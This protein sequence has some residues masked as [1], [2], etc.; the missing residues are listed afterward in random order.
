MAHVSHPFFFRLGRGCAVG[1][2]EVLVSP[3]SGLAV[4]C[5][6]HPVPPAPSLGGTGCKKTKI[7]FSSL[8]EQILRKST[9]ISMSLFPRLF[10][11]YRDFR[12]FLAMGVHKHY[13]K[14]FTKKPCRKV[15]TKKSQTDF[16]SVL[17]Y[18]VFGSF[19]VREFK[20]TIKNLGKKS[21]Q[22]WYCFGLRGTNQPR[23]GRGPWSVTFFLSAEC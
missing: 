20:N 3:V 17:F 13:K 18:H 1:T 8:R 9:K 12:C 14:R 7:K 4:R 11:F 10:L 5:A 23:R 15:F 19:S 22:P 16:F 21:G 2:A 6:P